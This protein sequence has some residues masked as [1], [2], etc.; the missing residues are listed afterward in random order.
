M[1]Q[2]I[3]TSPVIK[4]SRS[5]SSLTDQEQPT[6]IK[7]ISGEDTEPEDEDEEEEDEEEKD[8]ECEECGDTDCHKDENIVCAQQCEDCGN[9]LCSPCIKKLS[10]IWH[11]LA[12]TTD[13][14]CHN[15][16]LEHTRKEWM[17][18]FNQGKLS[19]ERLKDKM[20][21]LH[22]VELHKKLND[23]NRKKLE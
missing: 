6:K 8:N 2:E 3:V 12:E 17:D 1:S 9:W 23:P 13:F 5:P 20:M 18:L 19:E 10:K 15:C 7:T 22:L 4:R 11:G 16:Q 21:M 14:Y